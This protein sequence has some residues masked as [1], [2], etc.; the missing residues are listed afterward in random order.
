MEESLG[1]PVKC[2]SLS[3]HWR[4][5][6]RQGREDGSLKGGEQCEMPQDRKEMEERIWKT[7][8]WPGQRSS[9]RRRSNLQGTEELVKV[10]GFILRTITIIWGVLS[11]ED[12][13]FQKTSLVPFCG[14]YTWVDKTREMFRWGVSRCRHGEGR[15]RLLP[16]QSS[17]RTEERT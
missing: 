16:G 4:M 8:Q 6:A 12:C 2:N 7:F 5:N 17:K 14:Q 13:H 3:T 1:S 9:A 10:W 11:R 15:V